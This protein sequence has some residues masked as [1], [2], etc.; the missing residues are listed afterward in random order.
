MK[1]ATVEK[2]QE[3]EK[4]LIDA[5][6]VLRG[7]ELEERDRYVRE[8]GETFLTT[9]FRNVLNHSLTAAAELGRLFLRQHETSQ[10]IRHFNQC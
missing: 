3:V 5:Y 1:D 4:K 10:V 9:D 2:L 7:I 6:L 8:G